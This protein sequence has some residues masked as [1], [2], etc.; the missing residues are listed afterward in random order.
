MNVDNTIYYVYSSPYTIK[1]CFF[2]TYIIEG[3]NTEEDHQ[4]PIAHHVAVVYIVTFL[5]SRTTIACLKLQI[6]IAKIFWGSY[7]WVC[8]A[9]QSTFMDYTSL[10]LVQKVLSHGFQ[11]VTTKNQKNKGITCFPSIVGTA[12]AFVKCLV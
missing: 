12:C 11:M 10:L 5:Y 3:K 7:N 2:C 9:H 4:T 6:C 1:L 8:F